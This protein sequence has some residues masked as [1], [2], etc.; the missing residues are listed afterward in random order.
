M[1]QANIS[2]VKSEKM[3]K[4]FDFGFLKEPILELAH[5]LK[6]GQI[7]L[8]SLT[9]L[10][11]SYLAKRFYEKSLEDDSIF[12][13]I[14]PENQQLIQSFIELRDCEKFTFSCV[15]QCNLIISKMY[16]QSSFYGIKYQ[17]IDELQEEVENLFPLSYS[18]SEEVF[19]TIYEPEIEE[20]KKNKKSERY[21]IVS[22][23]LEN[24]FVR[25]PYDVI[26]YLE[27]FSEQKLLSLIDEI[28]SIDT[29]EDLRKALEKIH[30]GKICF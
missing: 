16:P 4:E 23:M 17:F 2:R 19:T 21:F 12:K 8:T 28:F 20:V 22:R 10:S 13:R 30:T 24:K 18:P 5:Q 3:N 15:T 14:S 25:L 7:A 9:L 26:A 11:L 1:D 29:I 6:P 27:L